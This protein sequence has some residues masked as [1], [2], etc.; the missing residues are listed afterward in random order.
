M[1]ESINLYQQRSIKVTTNNVLCT[2]LIDFNRGKEWSVCFWT[3]RSKQRTSEAW[4]GV[5]MPKMEG[6]CLVRTAKL[7]K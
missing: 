6:R 2:Y 7:D 1:F 3:R 4:L 5:Y